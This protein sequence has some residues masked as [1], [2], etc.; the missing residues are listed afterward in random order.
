MSKETR[1]YILN[2]ILTGLVM[3]GTLGGLFFLALFGA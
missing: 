3:G 1:R 2:E